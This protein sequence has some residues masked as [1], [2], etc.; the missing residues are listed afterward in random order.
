MA[1]H[2]VDAKR[3]PPRPAKGFGVKIK[4]LSGEI[5]VTA[6]FFHP[7]EADPNDENK[8]KPAWWDADGL[9]ITDQVTH[10]RDLRE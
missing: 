9:D 3:F 10:W 6:A 4:Q 2:W 7:K 8:V 1:R 5:G